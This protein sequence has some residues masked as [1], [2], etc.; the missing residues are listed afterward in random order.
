[1]RC[2]PRL[3]QNQSSNAQFKYYDEFNCM[4]VEVEIF[5]RFLF[6]FYALKITILVTL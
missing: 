6:R 1:M 2:F 3:T 5:K 4:L